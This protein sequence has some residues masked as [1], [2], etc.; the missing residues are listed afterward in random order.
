MSCHGGT[1]GP[2]NQWRQ[3]MNESRVGLRFAVNTDLAGWVHLDLDACDRWV[4][5]REITTHL[6]DQSTRRGGVGHATTDRAAAVADCLARAAAAEKPVFL[7]TV[8][9]AA[10]AVLATVDVVEPLR[11]DLGYLLEV[12]SARSPDIMGRPVLETL[13]PELADGIAVR[14]YDALPDG[15][16]AA[17]ITF[18]RRAWDHDIVVG[19]RTRDL[20]IVPACY[21]AMAHLLGA[22]GPCEPGEPA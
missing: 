16:V 8:L 9:P 3:S 6:L 4:L 11:D 20:G 12:A 13:P 14:R 17:T 7:A 2:D 22:V 1:G 5:E 15:G 19:L 21:T 10:E 18:A